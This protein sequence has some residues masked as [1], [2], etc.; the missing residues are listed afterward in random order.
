LTGSTLSRRAARFFWKRLRVWIISWIVFGA[1]KGQGITLSL[2]A[3]TL[4][5]SIPL[6]LLGS[7]AG[8]KI[9]AGKGYI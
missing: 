9:Q 5:I 4:L 1:G 2:F 3:L 7:Q 8:F 6:G